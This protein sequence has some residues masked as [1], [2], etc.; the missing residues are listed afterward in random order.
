MS[1]DYN[2]RPEPTPQAEPETPVLTK[3]ESESDREAR[4]A[5]E[6]PTERPQEPKQP[7][8]PLAPP[9]PPAP[10]VKRFWI[11]AETGRQIITHDVHPRDAGEPLKG[12]TVVELTRQGDSDVEVLVDG[13]WTDRLDIWNTRLHAKVDADAEALRNSIITPGSAQMA[14]YQA[15]ADEATDYLKH[16]DAQIKL[17]TAQAKAARWPYLT[18]EA[19]ACGESL[20]WRAALIAEKAA[21]WEALAAR[22]EAK[23]I[24]LKLAIDVEDSKLAKQALAEFPWRSLLG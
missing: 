19:Q 11:V 24:G 21:E 16:T 12:L 15:K 2:Y 18:A 3:P 4:L 9:K 8:A 23:R 6:Q 13:A 14:A 20:A 7:V 17:M 22:I 5:G 1:I 10:L